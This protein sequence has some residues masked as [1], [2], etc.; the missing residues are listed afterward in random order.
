MD[1]VGGRERTR[2]GDRL[3]FPRPQHVAATRNTP[4]ILALPRRAAAGLTA[5]HVA[6]LA[7][8]LVSQGT[9]V[10]TTPPYVY[11][12]LDSLRVLANLLIFRRWYGRTL[13]ATAAWRLGLWPDGGMGGWLRLPMAF[14][15]SGYTPLLVSGLAL[16]VGDEAGRRAVLSARLANSTS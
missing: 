12:A 4:P 13:T 7:L 9:Y 8:R 16:E 2:R 14:R 1:L 6:I 10:V 11:D 3:P 15:T 5:G